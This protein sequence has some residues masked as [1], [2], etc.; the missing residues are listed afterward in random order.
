MRLRNADSSGW[1]K[2]NG[3]IGATN[4]DGYWVGTKFNAALFTDGLI[5]YKRVSGILTSL[6]STADNISI[7]P[8]G[9]KHTFEIEANGT[10]ISIQAYD[11]TMTPVGTFLSKID[12]TFTG[13][14]TVG[15]GRHHHVT[16]SGGNRLVI[17]NFKV[18]KL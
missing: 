16:S 17:D 1:S 9:K 3:T 5:I 7:N 11:S 10:T 12:S 8:Q 14:G 13:P 2:I 4:G 6:G 15:I 18:E